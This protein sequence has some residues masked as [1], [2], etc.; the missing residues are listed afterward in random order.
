MHGVQLRVTTMASEALR[1]SN[2]IIAQYSECSLLQE[3]GSSQNSSVITLY[4]L[5]GKKTEA[6]QGYY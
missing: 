1:V 6:E 5:F 3:Y 4:Y 2:T